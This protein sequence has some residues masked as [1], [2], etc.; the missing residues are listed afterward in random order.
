MKQR[1]TKKA[2]L[3]DW[4]EYCKML[5]AD[6]ALTPERLAAHWDYVFGMLERADKSADADAEA[7]ANK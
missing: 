2:E 4:D 6:T 1:L 3:M 5:A 7:F